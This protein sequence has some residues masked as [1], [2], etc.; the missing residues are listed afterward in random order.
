ME[1]I[2]VY[3]EKS[4][5]GL[6]PILKKTDFLSLTLQ[7]GD[8]AQRTAI[9]IRLSLFSESPE[10]R[11]LFHLHFMSSQGCY[12]ESRLMLSLGNVISRLM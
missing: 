8:F 1:K 3:K 6:T 10:R 2:F 7:D 9:L 4:L 11:C 5:V 12:S